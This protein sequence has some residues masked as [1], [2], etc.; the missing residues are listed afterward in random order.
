MKSLVAVSVV[1]GLAVGTS[2]LAQT[3]PAQPRVLID[4]GGTMLGGG[5]LGSSDA[6]YTTS[7][8]GSFTL[9]ST[10]QSWSAGHGI[11]GHLEVR[12]APRVAVELSGDWTRPEIRS[13]ITSDFEGAAGTTATQ[14][15]SQFRANAGVVVSFASHGRWTPF[16]RGAVGWLRHLSSDN[17][18]YQDGV[19]A[20]LGGGLRYAWR[21][22]AGHV[23]PYGLRA[24]IWLN[25]RS[26]G[27]D[28]AQKSRI[29]APGVSVSFILKL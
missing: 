28:L 2:A 7:T 6:T 29:I 27:L 8:G 10:S 5:S 14:R 21:E 3:P 12:V 18:L 22:K 24:D 25:A 23:K 19:T 9:F 20:D 17:T 11:I 4:V 1:A 13:K 26:G 16:A 15:L